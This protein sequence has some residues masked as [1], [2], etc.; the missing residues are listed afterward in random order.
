[1]DSDKY[2]ETMNSYFASH[3]NCTA[4]GP[5][6]QNSADGVATEVFWLCLAKYYSLHIIVTAL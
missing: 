2:L 3:Y 6:V 4:S 1:M 5:T